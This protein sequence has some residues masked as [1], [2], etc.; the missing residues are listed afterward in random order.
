MI[1]QT[2]K[3]IKTYP[4][5]GVTNELLLLNSGDELILNEAIIKHLAGPENS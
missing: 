5:W 3:I 2:V 4:E 1:K